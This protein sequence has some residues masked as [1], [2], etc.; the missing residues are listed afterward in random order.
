MI[1]KI[2]FIALSVMIAVTAITGAGVYNQTAKADETAKTLSLYDAV[3]NTA[4][5]NGALISGETFDYTV[6]VSEHTVTNNAVSN[7]FVFKSFDNFD[8]ELPRLKFGNWKPTETAA[9][10]GTPYGPQINV[11]ASYS[12]AN[13]I[14]RVNRAESVSVKFVFKKNAKLSVTHDE[15]TGI[16]GTDKDIRIRIY[17]ETDGK[18]TLVTQNPLYSGSSAREANSLGAEINVKSG[19]TVYYEYGA[20]GGWEKTLKAKTLGSGMFVNFTA[21][22]ESYDNSFGL[23]LNGMAEATATNG[24]NSV[25]YNETVDFSV[26]HG[27]LGAEVPFDVTGTNLMQTTERN[28][29]GTYASVYFKYVDTL[30]RTNG[31]KDVIVVELTFKK[32]VKITVGSAAINSPTNGTAYYKY[33]VKRVSDGENF[34]KDL[35]TFKITNTAAEEN[36]IGFTASVTAGDS[37]VA[38]IY[39][40]NCTTNIFLQPDFEINEKGYNESEAFDFTETIEFAGFVK[41]QKAEIKRKYDELFSD[42]YETAYLEKLY[43]DFITETDKAETKEEVKAAADKFNA[44]INDVETKTQVT[45]AIEAAKTRVNDYVSALDKNK[46]SEKSY[47]EILSIKGKGLLDIESVKTSTAAKTKADEIIGEIGLLPVLEVDNTPLIIT[48]IALAVIL[49]AAAV[50]TVVI[51]KRRKKTK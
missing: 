42:T 7:D 16:V 45:A 34:Y 23:T 41:E 1:K 50:T 46:Y 26:K 37:F 8:K 9:L 13:G 32:N 40:S 17:T 11:N 14:I 33:Y 3:K 15:I 29:G 4:E 12:D 48:I 36:A 38:V 18:Q 24:F 28:D 22:T 35:E 43:N 31:E 44:L 19:T 21:D 51:L 25:E 6:G 20:V 49:G 47:N 10:S 39:G 27:K 5:N 30:M 2:K